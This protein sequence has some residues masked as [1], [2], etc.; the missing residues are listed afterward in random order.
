VTDGLPIPT[1]DRQTTILSAVFAAIVGCGLPP[2]RIIIGYR[3]IKSSEVPE[4]ICPF[5]F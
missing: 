4:P 2:P 5:S 1:C 3:R